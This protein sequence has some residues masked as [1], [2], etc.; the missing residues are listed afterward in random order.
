MVQLADVQYCNKTAVKRKW[1]QLTGHESTDVF[2][3][4]FYLLLFLCVT[5]AV[6]A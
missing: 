4:Y 6:L 5:R 1:C 2:I 3:Y